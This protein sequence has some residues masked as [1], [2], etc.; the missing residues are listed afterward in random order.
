MT[1]RPAIV[2]LCFF[3]VVRRE[4]AAPQHPRRRLHRQRQRRSRCARRGTPRRTGNWMAALKAA[5]LGVDD[6]DFVM[7]THLHGDHVGWNTRLENGRWVP[8]ASRKARYTSSRRRNTPTG[9]RSIRRPRSTTSRKACLPVIEANRAGLRHQRPQE[10]PTRPHSPHPDPGPH[11]R[12]F[13]G[14]RR[15]SLATKA[16]FTGDLIHSA[17]PGALSRA[18]DAG[19]LHRSRT[20][21]SPQGGA[22]FERYCDTRHPLLHDALPLSPSVGH[23]KRWG[24]GFKLDYVKD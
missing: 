3:P 18:G 14:L 20:R 19:R 15:A 23:V 7:C 4:D 16:V 17:D 8:T 13:R 11:A 9:A 24:D 5:G 10:T 1:R 12:P 6:I 21:P 2:S 22:F